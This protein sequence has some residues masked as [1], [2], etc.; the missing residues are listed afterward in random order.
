MEQRKKVF[1]LLFEQG[2]SIFSFCTSLHKLRFGCDGRQ[3]THVIWIY[4][5]KVRRRGSERLCNLSKVTWQA[6]CN[7]FKWNLAE[8]G[9]EEVISHHLEESHPPRSSVLD[10]MWV[11]LP[12]VLAIFGI[13]SHGYEVYNIISQVNNGGS[14]Q[15]TVTIDSEKETATIN[16]HAGSCSSTTIFDYKHGYIASRLLS[17]RACYILKM[18]RQTTPSLDQLKQSIYETK[19]LNNI[20]SNKYIWVKYNPLQSLITHMDWFLFGSPIKQLCKD[21][22]LYKGEVAGEILNNV[23]A[24][25]CAKAGL[26]GIFGISICA[27]IHI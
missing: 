12:V 2:G 11:L 8:E 22:P 17:R 21:V 3:D 7:K 6:D 27:D 23:G 15:E 13:Q 4:Q 24:G 18:N 10:F 1:V 26:L 16:I 14:V 5:N 20:F 25:S 9:A 19:A